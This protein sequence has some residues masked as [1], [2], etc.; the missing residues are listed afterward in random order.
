MYGLP[1]GTNLDFIKGTSLIQACFGP[2]DLVLNFDEKVSISISSSVAVGRVGTS[3]VRAAK[4]EA[5]SHDILGLLNRAVQNVTWT[6]N[7]TVSLIF[8]G[9]ELLE[10]YDDSTNY[11][12]YPVRGPMGLIVV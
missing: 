1:S 2:H 11:E 3:P 8:E 12:S 6:Q 5:I 9:N 4:F 7:G 10:I